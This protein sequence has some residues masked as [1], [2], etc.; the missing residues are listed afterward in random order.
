MGALIN[1]PLLPILGLLLAGFLGGCAGVSALGGTPRVPPP[2]YHQKVGLYV[3]DKVERFYNY[4][5]ASNDASN[6]MSFHLQQTLPVRIQGILQQM[7]EKVDLTEAGAEI[8]FKSPDLVGYFWVKTDS[9]RYDYPDPNLTLYRAEVELLIEFRTMDHELV[10]SNAVRG[11]G[12]GYANSS[13]RQS[14]FSQGASAAIEDAFQ[15]AVDQIE[16]DI[17]KSPSL[18]EHFRKQLA[19]P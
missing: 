2:E 8:S 10:W 7:F 6:W 1:R 18:R 14:S 15:R 17:F 13:Y 16:D 3:D 4:G 19:G 11:E 9:V 12:V 5:S